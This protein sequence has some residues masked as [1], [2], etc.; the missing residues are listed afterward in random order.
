MAWDA[1]DLTFIIA[2]RAAAAVIL[3]VLLVLTASL[4]GEYLFT[5]IVFVV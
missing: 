5:D 4:S 1:V 3:V 2:H